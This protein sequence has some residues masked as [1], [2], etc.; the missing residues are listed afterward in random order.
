MPSHPEIG[1][2]PFLMNGRARKTILLKSFQANP[3][4]KHTIPSFTHFSP[5][6]ESVLTGDTKILIWLR[7]Q[8]KPPIL[9]PLEMSSEPPVHF[10]M[11]DG[12]YSYLSTVTIT[13]IYLHHGG[14]S[15]WVGGSGKST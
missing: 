15:V 9:L 10:T 4:L 1:S 6:P 8:Q 12:D 3:P 5:S 11:S 14:G 13:I 7:K 2:L